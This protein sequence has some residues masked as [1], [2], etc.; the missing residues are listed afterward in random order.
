LMPITIP[1]RFIAAS[2][3]SGKKLGVGREGTNIVGAFPAGGDLDELGGETR[4]Y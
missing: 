3:E 1:M 2:P 4:T